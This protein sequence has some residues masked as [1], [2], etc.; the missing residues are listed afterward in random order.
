M[1]YLNNEFF[2]TLQLLSFSNKLLSTSDLPRCIFFSRV[3]FKSICERKFVFLRCLIQYSLQTWITS[4]EF[5]KE[6]LYS[7]NFSI[8]E[9]EGLKIFLWVT[10]SYVWTFLIYIR[11]ETKNLGIYWLYYITR[12][13]YCAVFFNEMHRTMMLGPCCDVR[14]SGKFKVIC[15]IVSRLGDSKKRLR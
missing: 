7:S 5:R 9:T 3:S 14:I 4:E 1:W 11:I 10:F 6:F 12:K 2:R 8:S 13:F 15:D